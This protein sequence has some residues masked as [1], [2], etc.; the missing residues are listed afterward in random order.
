MGV[1]SVIGESGEV[2]LE[3]SDLTA[4]MTVGRYRLRENRLEIQPRRTDTG[5]YDSYAMVRLM[6]CDAQR[7]NGVEIGELKRIGSQL[8]NATAQLSNLTIS[9]GGSPPLP[10][11][12]A[13]VRFADLLRTRERVVTAA[14]MEIAV[15]AFDPRIEQ[16]KVSVRADIVT[17]GVQAVDLVNVS[18]AVDDF[19]DPEA[20]IPR[21]LVDS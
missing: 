19:A 10:Y 2:Y 8:R 21:L 5:R 1:L 9:R 15:R 18:L 4:A 20:E 11:S 13:R 7:A 6:L 17:D 14:D 16:V 3:E 12:D